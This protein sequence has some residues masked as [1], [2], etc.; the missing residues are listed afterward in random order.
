MAFVPIQYGNTKTALIRQGLV[1]LQPV[2][3][4]MD[5]AAQTLGIHEG[6]H[7]PDTVGAAHRM[8]QPAPKEPGVSDEFQS[9]R[10][11]MRVQKRRRHETE[12]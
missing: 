5:A 4:V 6:G 8:P 9:V 3:D 12:F 11:P 2:V 1:A 7:T 10:L